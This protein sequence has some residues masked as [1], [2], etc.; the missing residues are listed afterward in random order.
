MW[1]SRPFTIGPGK[2]SVATF[3]PHPS[4]PS[5]KA[6]LIFGEKSPS[7]DGHN[8]AGTFWSDIWVYDFENDEWEEARVENAHALNQG[9]LGWGAGAI[10]IGD[11]VNQIVIWGGLNEHNERI[12]SGWKVRIST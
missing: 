1:K 11:D 7:S 10:E 6:I 8:A 12:G 4:Y 2:R 3:L 9:A 5:T